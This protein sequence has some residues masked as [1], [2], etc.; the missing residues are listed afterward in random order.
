MSVFPCR[1]IEWKSKLPYP[2]SFRMGLFGIYPCKDMGVSPL[3]C[4][5]TSTLSGL[6]PCLVFDTLPQISGFSRIPQEDACLR[7]GQ[8]PYYWSIFFTLILASLIPWLCS[9]FIE[10]ISNVFYYFLKLLMFWWGGTF[11]V[12]HLLHTKERKWKRVFCSQQIHYL[13]NEK[14]GCQEPLKCILYG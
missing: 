7:M 11:R 1:W 3:S 10:C 8:S 14:H 6:E 2:P 13:C 5:Q 12:S 9:S 4:I